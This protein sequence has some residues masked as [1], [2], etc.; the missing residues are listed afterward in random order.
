MTVWKS[1]E[2]NYHQNTKYV[3]KN[4][5]HYVENYLIIWY[6][7]VWY[8]MYVYIYVIFGGYILWYIY[9]FLHSYDSLG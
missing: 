7:G 2:K 9:L 1:I 6:Q 5:S 8:Y 4:L 3:Y